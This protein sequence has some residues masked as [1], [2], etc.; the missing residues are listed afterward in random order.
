MRNIDPNYTSLNKFL[1]DLSSLWQ[2][3]KYQAI[4]IEDYKSS[5]IGDTIYLFSDYSNCGIFPEQNEYYE[6]YGSAL[7]NKKYVSTDT[8]KCINE[9][10]D[11]PTKSCEVSVC[12]AYYI[13]FDKIKK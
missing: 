7:E 1:Q 10:L 12:S 13:E 2:M 8:L 6:I 9:E 3:R 11:I 4:I 5:V